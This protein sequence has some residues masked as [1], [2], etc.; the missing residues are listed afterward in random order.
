M[1]RLRQVVLVMG[2][3]LRRWR[4]NPQIWLAFG[5]GFVIC[6]LLS[7]KV[8]V[9]SQEHGTVLQMLEPFIWTFGDATSILI[10]SLCLL[11]LFADVPNI[12][13][14]VPFVLIR[15]SRLVWLLG[16]ILYVI[17][18][19]LL[20]VCFVLISTMLLAGVQS[21]TANLWSNTAAIL[22]YSDIGTQI[23]VPA[24]V[25][26]MEL[27]YPR[28]CALH[29]FGLVLG[30]SLLMSSL[31]LYL[32]LWR[33]KAGMVGGLIFSG[34]GAVMNPQLLSKW[35]QIPEERS[36][37]ANIIFGW[38]SPLN[39]GTYYM[40]NFGYDNLPR[41]WMSYVFFGVGSLLLFG[42]SLWR[43]RRYSFHFTGTKEAG[44]G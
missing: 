3:N 20:F 38:I 33:G 31:I 30:Y 7:N 6:F 14:E 4:K 25:K 16:Q 44:N 24:F 37:I 29:I 2:M 21:Y 36:R 41:L 26:V 13:T 8:L 18:A 1:D 15:T 22:G 27:T 10:I 34:F 32:N 39:H 17:V 19:T 23:A 42:L 12:G 9:F 11:L 28:Q 43:I 5:L 35:L 40:H